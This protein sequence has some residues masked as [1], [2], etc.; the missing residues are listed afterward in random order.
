MM[1]RRFW[2]GVLI[3]RNGES[4]IVVYDRDN[5]PKDGRVR[6]YRLKNHA[7]VELDR[8]DARSRAR[9]LK[10]HEHALV[11]YALSS[12]HSARSAQAQETRDIARATERDLREEE[13]AATEAFRG[14]RMTQCEACAGTG[15]TY[16]PGTDY[17]RAC[18]GTGW[19]RI[20]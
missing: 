19:H 6:L 8:D 12:Y 17:C 3:A 9:V 2:F 16:E 13:V 14:P 7:L 15:D 18:G 20:E 5:Q 1:S 11:G 4:S 10:E